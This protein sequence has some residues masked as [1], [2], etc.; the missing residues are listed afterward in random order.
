[1]LVGHQRAAGS[2]DR[3]LERAGPSVLDQQR[4]HRGTRLQRATEVTEALTREAAA[5]GVERALRGSP[6]RGRFE[7]E[8]EQGGH[9]PARALALQVDRHELPGVGIGGDEERLEDP[10]RAPA[11]DPLQGSHEPAFEVGARSEPVGEQLG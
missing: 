1:M 4:H 9:D 2:R 11:L 5:T 7:P 3:V 10:Q 6:S 8:A